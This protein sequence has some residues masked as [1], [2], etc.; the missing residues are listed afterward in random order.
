MITIKKSE[1]QKLYNLA[2]SSWKTKFDEKFKNQLFSEELELEEVFLEEMEKACNT[3]QLKVFKTIFKE[4][5]KEDLF[6]IKTYKEVCKKLKIKEL[7]EKDFK[8]FG[9]D[10]KKMLAF[11]KI[12]NLERVFNEKWVANWSNTSQYRYYPYF[13]YKNGSLVDGS[14]VGCCSDPD[15]FYGGVAFYKDS[16]TAVFVGEHFKDIYLDLIV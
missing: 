10:S 16:K 15:R 7:T 11:H 2:C 1:F 9:E 8:Q 6:S 5:Q 14:V 4:Y 3:D 13:Y 12:K